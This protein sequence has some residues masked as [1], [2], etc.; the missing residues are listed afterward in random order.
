MFSLILS[1]SIQLSFRKGGGAMGGLAFYLIVF[2]LFTFAMGPEGI[3]HYTLAVLSVALLLASV[4]SIPSIFERDHE[5]GMLEQ[6]SLQPLPLELVVLAKWLALWVSQSLP[7][8]ILSPLLCVM[9]GLDAAQILPVMMHIALLSFSMAAIAILTAALTV[10]AKRGGILPAL[11]SLPLTVPLV[12]F[13]SSMNG[14]GAILLL[15]AFALASVPLACFVS[16]I[17][18]KLFD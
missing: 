15:G 9:A 18:I 11:V 10:G 3:R 13:A 1:Q 4:V 5:D 2:T 14:A 6:Y 8:L 7:I 12:I 16:A 17:L